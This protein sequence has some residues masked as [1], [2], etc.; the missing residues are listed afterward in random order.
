MEKYPSELQGGG[1][2][3]GTIPERDSQEHDQGSKGGKPQNS[4]KGKGQQPPQKQGGK[5]SSG[6]KQPKLEGI[7]SDQWD[8][9]KS[10]GGTGKSSK[11]QGEGSQGDKG[12]SK[13]SQGKKGE[14][15]SKGEGSGGKQKAVMII[16][17]P[18]NPIY[19][20][21]DYLGD[22]DRVKGFVISE[23]VLINRLKNI[24]LLETWKNFE[25][26]N[27]GGRTPVDIFYLSS[28][29]Y[30]VVAY[31]PNSVEPTVMDKRYHPFNLSYKSNSL[32]SISGPDQWKNISEL[33]S[34]ESSSLQKFLTADLEESDRKIFNNYLKNAIGT[35]EGYFDRMQAILRSLRSYQYEMGMDEDMNV[36]KVKKFLLETKTG[37]CSE[38]SSTV[39]LLGRL[40]G[41]PSRVVYGYVASKDLQ[42]P[43]HRKGAS[44]IRKSIPPLQ[45]YPL[46][47]I[48]L[49]TTSHSHAWVQFYMPGY[50]WVD[51]ETT[52]YAKPP[53]PEMDPNSMDVVI[54]L[55]EEKP[56][57]LERKYQIP[58][59][60]LTKTLLILIGMITVGL[61][62]FRYG[63]EFYFL[64][65]S[66]KIT[67]RG[68]SSLYSYVLM[69]LAA[70][71]YPL[72]QPWNTPR[73]YA[74]V[75]AGIVQFADLYTMLR[76]R[77][78]YAPL[79]K[80][81][82][83]EDIHRAAKSLLKETEKK[84]FLRMVLRWINLRGI[85]Y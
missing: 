74:A 58:W 41:I 78:S 45:K 72:K 52:S 14:G 27:D 25:K 84:G 81:R 17:S 71:G 40:A 59:R 68:L 4:D 9:F 21:S 29:D 76:F 28:I 1:A 67:H 44:I 82:F 60:F 42:T 80:E 31:L 49:I 85:Y 79:E 50:G 48:Y 62:G 7:P 51:I 22:F 35:K 26:A 65:S 36:A 43:A 56:N 3:Q 6:K 61:Y 46:S 10:E 63:R 47:D 30:R 20:A 11:K 33:S 32:I 66:R 64:V 73:E 23:D 16:V 83:W 18:M 57:I 19:A 38:F 24:R 55:I 54:P 2:H 15:N 70:N 77:E 34:Q 8:N 37:D 12:D 39:A 53:K 13:G 75:H 5:D 69:R